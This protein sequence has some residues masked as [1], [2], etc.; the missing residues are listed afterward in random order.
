MVL[1]PALP[2]G[3]YEVDSVDLAGVDMS[4]VVDDGEGAISE[5]QSQRKFDHYQEKCLGGAIKSKENAKL[6][7]QVEVE[8]AEDVR[9]K[10]DN[11]ADSGS[12][13]QK[14]DKDKDQ[15]DDLAFLRCTMFSSFEEEDRGSKA[16]ASSESSTKRSSQ[17]LAA[18]HASPTKYQ[19]PCSS[20][21]S[22]TKP[23]S[24]TSLGEAAASP[25]ASKKAPGNPKKFEGKTAEEILNTKKTKII[26]PV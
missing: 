18:S 1:V 22:P 13:D 6:E 15:E 7:Q 11:E 20:I 12:E 21:M 26:K 16:G 25:A 19:R 23:C 24:S 9:A 10:S 5:N 2:E 14:D 4:E 3:E 8:D 17:T